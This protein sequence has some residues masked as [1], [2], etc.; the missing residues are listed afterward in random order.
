VD[1]FSSRIT[2]FRLEE[3]VGSLGTSGILWQKIMV[4]FGHIDI[5]KCWLAETKEKIVQHSLQKTTIS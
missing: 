1:I 4:F 5:R 3:K 2:I